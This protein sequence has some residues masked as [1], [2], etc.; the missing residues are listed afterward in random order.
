MEAASLGLSII[1]PL[2][3]LT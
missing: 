1:T 3:I 2:H